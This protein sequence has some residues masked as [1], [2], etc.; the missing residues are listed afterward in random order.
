MQDNPSVSALVARAGAV[1]EVHA[2]LAA[3]TGKTAAAAIHAAGASPD[4]PHD[5]EPSDD[6]A[7]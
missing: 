5:A 7:L 6:H 2:K 4:M 3:V 1:R